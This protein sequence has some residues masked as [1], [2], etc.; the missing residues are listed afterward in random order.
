M[1]SSSRKLKESD[2]KII[3]ASQLWK[4]KK[5]DSILSSSY[6]IDHIIPFSIS[7]DDTYINLQALCANC[8]C[9]KSQKESNRIIAYKKLNAIRKKALCWFCLE[10]LS[11]T[12]TC[13]MNLKDIIIPKRTLVCKKN[14]ERLN[15]FM[16]TSSNDEEFLC[17]EISDLTINYKN[18]LKIRLLPTVIFI[19]DYFS[20]FI[21]SENYHVDRICKE[22]EIYIS[23]FQKEKTLYSEIEIDLRKFNP[24]G[25]DHVPYDLIEHLDEYLKKCIP[26]YMLDQN[27]KTEYIYIV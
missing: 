5:C 27:V 2:K 9:Y 24:Y 6:Q 20:D 14:I 13:D 10:E 18:I 19:N 21:N 23:S 15:K 11:E 22:I 12:H 4:C 3:A 17:N 25:E 16:Y 26:E 7:N 1:M 8:H